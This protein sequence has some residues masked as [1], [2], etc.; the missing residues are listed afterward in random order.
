MLAEPKT[1]GVLY[2]NGLSH[3]EDATASNQ[4]GS[5]H[6]TYQA[7]EDQEFHFDSVEDTAAALSTHNL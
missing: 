6:S 5:V 7:G 2:T 1:N 4:P 3:H